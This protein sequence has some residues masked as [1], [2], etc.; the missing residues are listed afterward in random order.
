MS[1]YLHPLLYALP[2]ALSASLIEAL[3]LRRQQHEVQGMRASA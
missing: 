1:A 2:I 3:D